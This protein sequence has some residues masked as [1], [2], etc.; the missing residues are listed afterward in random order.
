MFST[1]FRPYAAAASG[2]LEGRSVPSV[3][4]F[5]VFL[6]LPPRLLLFNGNPV[7]LCENGLAARD[8]IMKITDW[9]HSG[10]QKW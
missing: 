1:F 4:V 5:P 10:A 7:K 8:K 6:L 3:R 9:V 2:C